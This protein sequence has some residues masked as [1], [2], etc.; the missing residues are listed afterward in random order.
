VV[1]QYSSGSSVLTGGYE[2]I[3]VDSAKI[4][5]VSVQDRQNGIPREFYMSPNY[6][7]PFN[8]STTIEFGLPKASQVQIV[9]YNVLGQ[10][11]AVLL[12]RSMKAGNYKMVFEAGRLASGV[13]F[14]VLRA[15]E[16]VF[17]QKMLL[18]K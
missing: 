9:V 17:K 13:Y 11:V 6:P 1:N 12:D 15:G 18:L 8:P 10:R 4:I 5:V 16:K 14:Y 3:P 7:N 2:L